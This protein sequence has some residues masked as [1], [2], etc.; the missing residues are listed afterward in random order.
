MKTSVLIVVTTVL[1]R[2]SLATGNV[3]MLDLNPAI[4]S[5]ESAHVTTENDVLVA[6]SQVP[7]STS[8]EM[9]INAALS[10]KDASKFTY[11]SGAQGQWSLKTLGSNTVTYRHSS[12]G[13]F[14]LDVEVICPS[15]TI[16][17]E[18]RVMQ[19]GGSVFAEKKCSDCRVV[20]T[21]NSGD[22]YFRGFL[23]GNKTLVKSV[24][25]TGIPMSLL[26]TQVHSY[27]AFLFM[28]EKMNTLPCQYKTRPIFVTKNSPKDG[29]FRSGP[30]KR[31]WMK[32]TVA[33]PSCDKTVLVD[34]TSGVVLDVKSLDFATITA[35]MKIEIL[36]DG[37]QM[38]STDVANNGFDRKIEGSTKPFCP[39]YCNNGNVTI[40]LKLPTENPSKPR[41][42]SSSSLPQ[43]MLVHWVA[44]DKLD[45]SNTRSYHFSL[46]QNTRRTLASVTDCID[47]ESYRSSA[48]ASSSEGRRALA[49]SRRYRRFKS[50]IERRQQLRKMHT[51][52]GGG[53]VRSAFL[54]N[55]MKNRSA[56][57][58]RSGGDQQCTGQAYY[59]KIA[60]NEFAYGALQD[61]YDSLPAGQTCA[62][63]A[64]SCEMY[65]ECHVDVCTEQCKT[66]DLTKVQRYED[67][68][69]SQWCG[70]SSENCYSQSLPANA[71]CGDQAATQCNSFGECELNAC[72]HVC[73]P[74]YVVPGSDFTCEDEIDEF[75][76]S[77]DDDPGKYCGGDASQCYSVAGIP[78]TSA[79]LS[80]EEFCA[81]QDVSTCETNDV[82]MVTIDE[83][84]SN[85]CNTRCTTYVSNE[86]SCVD[87]CVQ[88]LK[89]SVALSTEQKAATCQKIC[90]VRASTETLKSTLD[91]MS[92]KMIDASYVKRAT[93]MKTATDS[94]SNYLMP[95]LT[96]G[97]GA[98]KDSGYK[99]ILEI[100]QLRASKQG[101][102]SAADSIAVYAEH[103]TDS[104]L[105][106][107]LTNDR[108][109]VSCVDSV[110]SNLGTLVLQYGK[111]SWLSIKTKALMNQ[112]ATVYAKN[113]WNSEG[114]MPFFFCF[115]ASQGSMGDASRYA[116]HSESGYVPKSGDDTLGKNKC[117]GNSAVHFVFYSRHAGAMSLLGDYSVRKNNFVMMP[118]TVTQFAENTYSVCEDSWNSLIPACSSSGGTRRLLTSTGS[119]SE[120]RA[121]F[122]AN[123]PIERVEQRDCPAGSKRTSRSS[124]NTFA[125][126]NAYETNQYFATL[127]QLKAA[128]CTDAV[129]SASSSEDSRRCDN[130]MRIG[131]GAQSCPSL[132]STYKLTNE[133]GGGF[134]EYTSVC[135]ASSP[136][137]AVV[138]RT[139]SATDVAELVSEQD[140]PCCVVKQAY[141]S[142][143]QE[144]KSCCQRNSN[145]SRV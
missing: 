106:T 19:G 99:N 125:C 113:G 111:S 70:G 40:V 143:R 68:P 128:K 71:A 28:L 130:G 62:Q 11:V 118:G 44:T 120:V 140:S 138:P 61:G 110:V 102:P 117:P 69:A 107:E 142:L 39:L 29:T 76:K 4:A 5:I 13:L 9:K 124:N 87:T 27:T 88:S 59:E 56:H 51:S 134:I 36:C 74:Y 22:K 89:A 65:E 21:A 93:N 97:A 95:Y 53:L 30:T 104:E 60:Q 12:N 7:C 77:L 64:N 92:S 79:G 17:K 46:A 8:D 109:A 52:R 50:V 14:R 133:G 33:T 57:A 126:W 119:S 32:H 98:D 90:D 31:P 67:A 66:C 48:G 47:L 94:I 123:S 112:T 135:R 45:A 127:T 49:R 43:G 129:T 55:R 91:E 103:K 18:P 35:G 82:C 141:S 100:D 78:A 137:A 38:L 145:C 96:G 115:D 144:Q 83:E 1:C 24:K 10:L 23:S 20:Y 81:Q 121:S 54:W 114:V 6:R 84:S 131:N 42:S 85:S 58:R 132:S 108:A 37:S 116:L 3:I 73:E 26:G 2:A 25:P 101:C 15:G 72:S 80:E 139:Y 86:P 75:Y 63:N 41:D 136:K 122:H 105:E 16:Y 34:D